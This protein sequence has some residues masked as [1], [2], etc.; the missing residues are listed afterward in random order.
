MNK[1]FF[2]ATLLV[3]FLVQQY[4]CQVSEYGQC[5]GKKIY[6]IIFFI[7]FSKNFIIG[8][9]YGGSRTCSGG[10]TCYKQHQW[11]SQCL[12]SCPS[13]W[14]CTAESS[15]GATTVKSNVE[16]QLYGQCGGMVFKNSLF[17]IFLFKNCFR[18]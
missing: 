12:K 2:I 9:G 10:L 7:N 3:A 6:L 16:A 11:Y 5:G 8:D 4:S 17:I 1:S 15:A 18:N 13:G 14:D